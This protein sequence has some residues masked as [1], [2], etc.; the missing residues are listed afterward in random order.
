M[1]RAVLCHGNMRV[2]C[3][4]P[5]LPLFSSLIVHKEIKLRPTKNDVVEYKVNTQPFGFQENATISLT[6][7]CVSSIVLLKVKIR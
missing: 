1:C 7:E 4:L 2:L 5:L 3:L 6:V